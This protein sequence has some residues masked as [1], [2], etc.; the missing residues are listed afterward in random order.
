MGVHT[1]GV[2]AV[3]AGCPGCCC[4]SGA[5]HS[6]PRQTLQSC[7]C[8]L[9]HSCFCVVPAVAA[10]PGDHG[11]GAFGLRSCFGSAGCWGGQWQQHWPG[12]CR[13][14]DPGSSACGRLQSRR[15]STTW[16]PQ[17]TYLFRT[18]AGST[19]SA[20]LPPQADALPAQCIAAVW[21]LHNA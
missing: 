18:A 7:L 5:P 11:S 17:R 4:R 21:M 9:P 10:H 14:A 8:W 19:S 2:L 15:S 3:D 1:C 16:A 13:D 6:Y 20:A 12:V